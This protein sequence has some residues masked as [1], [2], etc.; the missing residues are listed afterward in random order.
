MLAYDLVSVR[1]LSIVRVRMRMAVAVRMGLAVSMRV[2][3]MPMRV[4]VTM[5]MSVRMR[6]LARHDIDFRAGD[7][8]AA[9]LAHLEMRAYVQGLRSVR[10]GLKGHARVDES[11]EKH[12]A[13]QAGEA[14]QISNSHAS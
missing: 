4:I 11:A 3:A 6:V 7:A 5:R 2:F 14:L 13:A 9:D 12:V 10:Q 1:V 8:A